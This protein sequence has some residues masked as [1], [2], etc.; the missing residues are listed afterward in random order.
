[1]AVEHKDHSAKESKPL[2][3]MTVKDL[4]EI[5]LAIPHEHTEVAVSDM[6]KDELVAFIKKARGITVG[7][8]AARQKAEPKTELT[9]QEIKKKISELREEK[10]SVQD[11]LR[12][13]ILRRRINRLKKLS[14]KS[15]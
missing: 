3:K 15:A 5:A 9:K 1:M 2:E 14:R 12:A 13:G 11:K 4:K 6:R 7:P 8:P 10:T